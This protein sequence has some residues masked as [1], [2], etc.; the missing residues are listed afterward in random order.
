MILFVARTTQR[1]ESILRSP[2]HPFPSLQQHVLRRFV[3]GQPSHTN[4]VLQAPP[5]KHFRI[6][7][8]LSKPVSSAE[9]P[10]L[11]ATVPYVFPLPVPFPTRSI[12]FLLLRFLPC[13]SQAQACDQPLPNLS[14]RPAPGALN[15]PPPQ[16][17]RNPVLSLC[18]EL[19]ARVNRPILPVRRPCHQSLSAFSA[20]KDLQNTLLPPYPV[21]ESLYASEKY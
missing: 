8:S 13:C 7:A 14:L 21:L 4:T 17:S 15:S 18:R 19:V 12:K 2:P 20:L 6:R 11:R 5:I 1:V 3:G 9:Q 16:L 10:N